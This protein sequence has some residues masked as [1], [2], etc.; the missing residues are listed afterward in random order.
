MYFTKVELHNFGIYKG[1]HEMCLTNQIGNRNISFSTA[2]TSSSALKQ[3]LVFGSTAK[4]TA[5]IVVAEACFK[6]IRALSK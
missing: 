1:T 5:P 6:N 3:D 2:A 4:W